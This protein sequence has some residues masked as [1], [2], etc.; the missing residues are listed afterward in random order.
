MNRKHCP[1]CGGSL[2]PISFCRHRIPHS[3]LTGQI[4]APQSLRQPHLL[5]WGLHWGPSSP[6]STP[7][8]PSGLLLTAAIWLAPVLPF[9]CPVRNA[10]SLP[11]CCPHLTQEPSPNAAALSCLLHSLWTDEKGLVWLFLSLCLC[12][13]RPPFPRALRGNPRW[14]DV[15]NYRRGET[16]ATL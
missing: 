5:H 1:Q 12:K 14:T 13:S 3:H 2:K 7:S 6:T 9:L 4:S 15:L 11:A 8:R 16:P 10:L